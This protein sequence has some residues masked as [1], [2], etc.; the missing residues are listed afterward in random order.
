MW[1]I[2]GSLVFIYSISVTVRFVFFLGFLQMSELSGGEV[3]GEVASL[4]GRRLLLTDKHV[5]LS[6]IL[7]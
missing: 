6:S 3:N 4:K 1:I 2:L 5:V 7:W